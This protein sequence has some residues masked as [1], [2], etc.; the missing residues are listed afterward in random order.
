VTAQARATG[1]TL[2]RNEPGDLPRIA[3]EIASL[4]GMLVPDLCDAAMSNA[5][6]VL[7][8]L[9]QLVLARPAG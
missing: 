9:A 8:K 5:L 7:P 6:R 3:G 4:R 2:A 1:H